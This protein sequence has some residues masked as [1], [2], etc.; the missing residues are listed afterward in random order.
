MGNNT[1]KRLGGRQKE[2]VFLVIWSFLL[3]LYFDEDRWT[4]KHVK[5]QKEKK[6]RSTTIRKTMSQIHYEEADSLAGELG[7]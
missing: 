2:H 1:K 6:N 4:R 3:F 7:C 5:M